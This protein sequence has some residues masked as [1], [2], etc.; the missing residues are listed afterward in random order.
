MRVGFDVFQACMAM[1]ASHASSDAQWLRHA[2][3][4]MFQG[5][6]LNSL[7]CQQY[8]TEAPP[9]PALSAQGSIRLISGLYLPL[10]VF[11]AQCGGVTRTLATYLTVP[12]LGYHLVCAVCILDLML[13]D[14]S[15]W[16]SDPVPRLVLAAIAV[17]VVVVLQTISMLAAAVA[18]S[19][20]GKADVYEARCSAAAC[21]E[22]GGW[23]LP[24]LRFLCWHGRLSPLWVRD[25]Q[26]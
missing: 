18:E 8:C 1:Q 14:V 23:A 4:V 2:Q 20:N 7:G 24:D 11:E 5:V 17:E 15:R 10:Q 21:S 3:P 26:Q 16:W 6:D 19:V 22:C 12:A 25:A 9:M 13:F